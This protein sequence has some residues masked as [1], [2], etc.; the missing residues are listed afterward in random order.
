VTKKKNT[1]R[2]E[3]EYEGQVESKKGEAI[4][5]FVLEDQRTASG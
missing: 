5:V 2:Q 1:Q 3:I 4:E